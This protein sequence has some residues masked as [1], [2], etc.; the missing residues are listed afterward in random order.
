MGL[1]FKK[2]LNR[3]E[4]ASL[5][6][7]KIINHKLLS[8]SRNHVSNGRV[9]I[10]IFA[11]D[12]IS[13]QINLHGLYEK[14]ELILLEKFLVSKNVN[15]KKYMCLDIGANIGNHSIY[16]ANLF[17][18]VVAFE[19]NFRT[20][21]LLALNVAHL[22]NVK[23]IRSGASIRNSKTFMFETP[24]NIGGS[25]I[26]KNKELLP[27]GSKLH[28]IKLKSIDSFKFNKVLLIKIDTE[29]HELYVIKGAKKLITQDKPLIVFEHIVDSS[30]PNNDV[31]KLLKE[32]GYTKF[33]AMKSSPN[34]QGKFKYFANPLFG[35]IFGQRYELIEIRNFDKQSYAFVIAVP[36]WID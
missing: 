32:Y 28:T 1:K 25:T 23:V 18:K 6:L 24:I 31:V 33:I 34:L 27:S 3:T 7:L 14:E 4:F 19:P 29:G 15:L 11:F 12:Y 16:F 10:R 13:H 35:L 30:N 8:L 5:L 36:D 21:D 22:N 17:N 20:A 26:I 2:K 9:P